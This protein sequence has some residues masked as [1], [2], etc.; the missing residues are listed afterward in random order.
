MSVLITTHTMAETEECDRLAL[1]FAGRV[2]REA[3]PK[4]LK[5]EVTEQAGQLLEVSPD[6]PATALRQLRQNDSPTRTTKAGFLTEVSGAQ[7][8]GLRARL[9]T[10]GPGALL[11]VEGLHQRVVARG[12]VF[13]DQHVQLAQTSAYGSLLAL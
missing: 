9:K 11:T 13:G 5:E 6:D 4:A 12:Q 3:S 7:V 1:M 10:Q 8:E 2:V